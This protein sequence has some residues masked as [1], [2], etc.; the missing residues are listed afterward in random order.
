MVWSRSTSNKNKVHKS[1]NWTFVKAIPNVI[2]R[3]QT[4]MKKAYE[5]V[6]KKI[7]HNSETLQEIEEL[8]EQVKYLQSKLNAIQRQNEAKEISQRNDDGTE[9]E[10]SKKGLKLLSL[11]DQINIEKERILE[12]NRSRKTASSEVMTATSVRTITRIPRVF[13][14]NKT[15]PDTQSSVKGSAHRVHFKENVV[16]QVHLR[17]ASPPQDPSPKPR[18]KRIEKVKI[19]HNIFA[20]PSFTQ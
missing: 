2:H 5:S 15:I 3:L 19:S 17:P 13:H 9:S 8:R 4:Q 12:G 1:T 16:D 18:G 14:D 20:T 6:E 10:L 11:C 7:F